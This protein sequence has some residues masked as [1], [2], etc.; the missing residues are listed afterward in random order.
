L[1]RNDRPGIVEDPAPG[2]ISEGYRFDAA[3]NLIALRRADQADPAKRTYAYDGLDRLT[4]VRDGATNALLQ[5]Y[6]YDATGNRTRRS[7][8]AAAIDYTYTPGSHRL[9]SVGEQDRQYDAVGNTLWIGATAAPAPAPGSGGGNGGGE[10]ETQPG[11]PGPGPILPPGGETQSA[12]FAAG[13]TRTFTYD[14]ANR[15]QRVSHDGV[16]AMRYFYNGHGERVHRAGGG[17][18]ITTV[19]DEDGSWIGDY[20]GNGQPLQ[21]AIWLDDLPV[22]LLVGTGANRSCITSKPIPWAR[23]GWRSTRTAT[24]QCGRGIPRT[25]RSATARRMKIRT[26]TGK[27]SCSTCD[28]RASA[29]TAR[30]DWSTT[31]TAT[32][33]RRRDA[34]CRATRSGWKAG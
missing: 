25:K 8:G 2:G 20:D 12:T 33:T 10:E 22:G 5:H 14:A 6:A 11:D 32:T 16:E 29:T 9:A 24:S 31:I 19:Y 13:V 34:T 21:Q 15:L 30:A 28:S 4:Q 18:A 23:R 1:D 17:V 26:A 3:G 27:R 7:D